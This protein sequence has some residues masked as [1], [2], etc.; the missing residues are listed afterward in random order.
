MEISK[1]LLSAIKSAPKSIKTGQKWVSMPQRKSKQW[2][3]DVEF[4][5]S[6]HFN[7]N[8][9]GLSVKIF[10]RQNTL[11]S[12]NFSC[13]IQITKDRKTTTLS[14]YNGSNHKNDIA[15]YECHIHHATV[16]SISR[17]DRNPEH[18]NT[19]V[20]DRYADLDG[21]FECLRSDYNLRLPKGF[22]SDLFTYPR[23]LL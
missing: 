7:A 23:V 20:T 17:G 15:N 10:A 9:S 18:E 22:E 12:E 6:E 14:R 21:A 19:Q 4:D 16:E 3:F 5:N 2:N 1:E 11:D 8:S 13:G